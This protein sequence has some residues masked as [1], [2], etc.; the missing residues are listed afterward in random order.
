MIEEQRFSTELNYIEA[1]PKA[2]QT[3]VLNSLVAGESIRLL[4]HKPEET[5]GG[6]TS[7]PKLLAITDRSFVFAELADDRDAIATRCELD[8]VVLV[9][10][11]SLLLYGHLRVHF[12]IGGATRA[13]TLEHNMVAKDLY[14]RATQLLLDDSASGRGARRSV[15]REPA[16]VG[17][18]GS[19]PRLL[20]DAA[21]ESRLPGDQLEAAAWWPSVR[22]GFGYQLAPMGAILSAGGRFAVVRI[23]HASA[24]MQIRDEPTFGTIV[25]YVPGDRVAGVERHHGPRVTVYELRVHAHHAQEEFSFVVPPESEAG[26]ERVLRAVTPMPVPGA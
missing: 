5:A 19:W 17:E 1:A 23:E 4:I 26:V 25:T 13:V 11:A 2:F 14:R 7:P 3:A 20:L 18:Y 15:V 24:W 8:R 16:S 6:T 10:Q 22:G 21:L 12:V 9:E